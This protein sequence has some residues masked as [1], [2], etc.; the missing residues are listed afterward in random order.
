MKGKNI[1]YTDLE[2]YQKFLEGDK[3]ALGFLYQRLFPKL[4]VYSF[5]LVQKKPLAKDMVQDAFRKLIE[6]P[7]EEMY[8]VEGYLR[9]A[10]RNRWRSDLRNRRSRLEHLEIFY[11]EASKESN[12]YHGFD[13]AILKELIARVLNPTNAQIILLDS[14]GFKNK[15]IAEELGITEKQVRERKSRSKKLLKDELGKNGFDF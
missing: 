4:F 1:Q 2:L 6:N 15:E 13:L 12:P 7:C 11:E 9:N 3:H 10:I 5:H 8:Q 14:R